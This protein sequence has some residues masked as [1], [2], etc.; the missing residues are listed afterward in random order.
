[1][2]LIP[3]FEL[4]L[5]NAWIFIIPLIVYWIFGVKF[6]FSKRM[7][8]SPSIKR[9]KDKIISNMLVISMFFSFFYSVF[10]PFKLGTIW[11]FSGLFVYLAGMVL[12]NLTMINFVTT[13]MDKPVTKGV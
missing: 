8:E 3:D 11:F 5:W 9:R 2:S 6:L 13:P 12:I 4:G 7:P 10:V 1:M